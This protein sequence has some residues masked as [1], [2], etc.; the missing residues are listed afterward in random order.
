MVLQDP[1]L[2]ANVIG[3]ERRVKSLEQR[4]DRLTDTVIRRDSGGSLRQGNNGFWY[5]MTFA[6]WMMV[7]LIVAFMYH[8]K[9]SL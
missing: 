6:G 5:V 8:Y 1:A 3:L 4:V 7:P 2:P 9:K